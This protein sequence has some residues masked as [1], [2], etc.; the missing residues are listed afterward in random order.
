MRVN[1][2][3]QY[4][5]GICVFARYVTKIQ[6]EISELLG[7]ASLEAKEVHG[8]AI[9]KQFRDVTNKIVNAL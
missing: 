1:M 6:C 4:V 5:T 3:I 7:K 9:R 8:N 2:D